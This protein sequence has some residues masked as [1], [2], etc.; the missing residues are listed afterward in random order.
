LLPAVQKVREAASRSKCSNNLK[1]ITLALHSY[2][3]TEG[4]FPPGDNR[5]NG[6]GFHVYILPYIEQENLYHQFNMAATNYVT[7]INAGMTLVPQYQ[8]P[9][10]L[11]MRSQYGGQEQVGGVDTYTAHYYGVAGPNGTNP[12]TGAAYNV[13]STSQGGIATQGILTAIQGFSGTAQGLSTI[14]TATTRATDITDGT[15][16]TLIV[17]EI[18]WDGYATYRVWL[19]GNFNDAGSGTG[20]D[21]TSCK[22]VITAFNSTPYNGSNNQN[23]VSFGSNHTGGGANFA[24]ADGSVRYLSPSISLSVYFSAASMNGGETLSLD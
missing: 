3:S 10:A 12:Q 4:R 14:S 11:M 7:N 22:N 8:C 20:G 5:S 24:L 23:N 16:R 2:H 1:Q 21:M 13:V 19:R 9:Q 15:S 6:L 17:G 18:S